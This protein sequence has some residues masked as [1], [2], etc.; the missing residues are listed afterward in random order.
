MSR[1]YFCRAFD[2]SGIYNVVQ[3]RWEGSAFIAVS[4]KPLEVIVCFTGYLWVCTESSECAKCIFFWGGGGL[5]VT[6]ARE[7]WS[8]I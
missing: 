7:V 1:E 3:E 8:V 5:N 6:V 4:L 2:V